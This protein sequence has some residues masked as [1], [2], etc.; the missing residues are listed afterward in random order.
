[1]AYIETRASRLEKI[2]KDL[3][4]AITRLEDVCKAMKSL[5]FDTVW[6]QVV[7]AERFAKS[8][9]TFSR[10]AELHLS[11]QIHCKQYGGEPLYVETQ[12]RSE[13]NKQRKKNRDSMASEGLIQQVTTSQ[14]KKSTTKK[15]AKR[16]GGS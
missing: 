3:K 6:L 16:K 2:V 8:I 11:D 12:K 14:P 1:M 5:P 9:D 13:A 15:P 10:D 7:S 4:G